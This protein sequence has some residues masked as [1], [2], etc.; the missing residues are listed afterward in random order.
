MEVIIKVFLNKLHKILGDLPLAVW[1][2]VKLR[3][4]ASSIISSYFSEETNPSKNSE[5]WLIQVVAPYSS[6]FVDVGAN[7]GN[8]S[9]LFINSAPKSVQGILFEPSQHTL[10]SLRQ[11]FSEYQN[12]KIIEKGVGHCEGEVEFFDELGKGESS[13]I[14]QKA[15]L[16]NA[17]KTVVKLTSLDIELNQNNV[18][19]VDFLKI[20]AEGYDFQVLKGAV[21]FLNS[22]SIGIIQFEYGPGW[23]HGGATLSAAVSL[24][25]SFGYQVFLLKSHQLFKIDFEFYGEYFAYSNYVAVSPAKISSLGLNITSR[26]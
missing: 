8:W 9:S 11:R 23:K 19:Y 25:K 5:A 12:I 17:V 2:A 6:T 14:I 20:D 26:V 15:S 7:I 1:F 24:L 4:Q 18:S 21:D 3:N 22:Q 10:K 16:K 13:S